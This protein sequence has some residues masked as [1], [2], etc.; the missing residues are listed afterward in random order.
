M[1]CPGAIRSGNTPRLAKRDSKL[2][3]NSMF[4]DL[5]LRWYTLSRHSPNNIT[6]IAN[7]HDQRNKDL[8]NVIRL[9]ISVP[10]L[11]QQTC[12][13]S[14]RSETEKSSEAFQLHVNWLN[15]RQIEYIRITKNL[16]PSR[17]RVTLCASC[18]RAG[19]SFPDPAN[20]L[21]PY[22]YQSFWPLPLHF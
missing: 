15:R 12:L 10:N 19:D 14:E 17:M 21:K 9:V 11:V 3:F 7:N 18:E 4:L 16:A 22:Q 5:G 20:K 13:T 1:K 6:V 2:T 8:H